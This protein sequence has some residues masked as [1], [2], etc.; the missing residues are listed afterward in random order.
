MDPTARPLFALYVVWH[1][2][3]ENG[4]KIADLLRRRFGGDRYQNIAGD[5]GVSVLCR[6]EAVLNGLVPLPIDW[7]EVGTTV[8]VVLADATLAG[9]AAWVSYVRDLVQSAQVGGLKYNS[10]RPTTEAGYLLRTVR[11]KFNLSCFLA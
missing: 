3:Y 10:N 8:V 2:S 4:S 5:S 1:P 9:D 11:Q 7:G 6:S